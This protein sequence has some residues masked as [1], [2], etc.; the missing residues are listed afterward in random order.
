M[1]ISIKFFASIREKTGKAEDS[2][3][4]SAISTVSDVW[5]QT[6]GTERPANLLVAVNQEYVGWDFTPRDGDEV[7]FFPPVT[8]G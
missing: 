6:T 1:S 4:M 8:G 5:T 3:D 2:I 7:A